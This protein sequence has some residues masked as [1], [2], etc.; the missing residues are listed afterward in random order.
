[1]KGKRGVPM[2]YDIFRRPLSWPHWKGMNRKS[3]RARL[4]WN[5]SWSRW[6]PRFFCWLGFWVLFDFLFVC[7]EQIGR[8]KEL[9][10]DISGLV[11]FFPF[12]YPSKNNVASRTSY[13]I[14]SPWKKTTN[15]LILRDHNVGVSGGFTRH[16]SMVRL[17]SASGPS[18]LQ[19]KK[20][21]ERSCVM[22]C[23]ATPS[24]IE[25]ILYHFIILILE[26]KKFWSPPYV[27]WGAIEMCIYIYI[28]YLF[29]HFLLD[30]MRVA[31]FYS[32]GDGQHVLLVATATAGQWQAETSLQCISATW[33]FYKTTY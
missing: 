14:S 11:L 2:V 15:K 5:L 4:Q 16:T 9:K 20:T 1:M 31:A 13:H 19:P 22:L 21:I 12:L 8:A 26:I 27:W 32:T 6:R 25:F 29:V 28:L 18:N 3:S 17:A 33:L 24:K 10:V 30:G 7:D 23:K